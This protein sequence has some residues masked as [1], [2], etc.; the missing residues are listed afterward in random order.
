MRP[1]EL[2]KGKA[3]F[4]NW[5]DSATQSGWN[6]GEQG[7]KPETIKSLAFVV[8]STPRCL[9]LSTSITRRGGIVSALMIPWEAIKKVTLVG[10]P[11]RNIVRQKS[12]NL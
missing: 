11:G 5:V 2:P 12:I 10:L 4:V 8:Q 1:L 7:F 9:T 3:V 6:Y